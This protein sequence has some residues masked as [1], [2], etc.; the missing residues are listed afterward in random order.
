MSEFKQGDPVLMEARILDSAS[1]DSGCYLIRPATGKEMFAHRRHLH[2][3]P[4]VHVADLLEELRLAHEILDLCYTDDMPRE[5][6]TPFKNL[7]HAREAAAAPKYKEGDQVW[8]RARWTRR[9]GGWALE[10]R[11]PDADDKW[12]GA[13]NVGTVFTPHP[14]DIKADE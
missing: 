12:R 14:D 6:M 8:V 5:I 1:D 4:G 3:H 2:R 11:G 7:W 10:V 13:G 9:V